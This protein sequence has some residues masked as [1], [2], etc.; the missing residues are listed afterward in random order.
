MVTFLDHLF[1]VEGIK[2]PF[3]ICVPLSTIGHWKREFEGK[4][5]LVLA[6]EVTWNAFAWTFRYVRCHLSLT[7]TITLLQ[8][9]VT[10]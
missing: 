6:R 4:F 9:G 5:S 3:L 2:G 1:E 10:W 7:A 8:A